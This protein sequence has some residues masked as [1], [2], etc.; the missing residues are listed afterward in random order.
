[1]AASLGIHAADIRVVAVYEGSTII[2]FIILSS[3]EDEEPLNLDT[4][5][6]TFEEVVSTM[7]EFMGSTVLNAV[8]VGAP[9]VTPNTVVEDLE[10]IN[11]IFNIINEE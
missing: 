9:I 10:N 4:V 6:E 11:D 2:D 7:D 3:Q 1:M 5:Q 8:S